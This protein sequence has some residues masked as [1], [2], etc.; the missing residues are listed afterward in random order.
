MQFSLRAL[1]ILTTLAALT[2]WIVIW[3]PMAAAHIVMHAVL[4]VLFVILIV[5]PW[6]GLTVFSHWLFR[7]V[8]G[9]RRSG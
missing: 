4:A 3:Y 9:K 5:A 2:A 1:F 7:M 6:M 8:R